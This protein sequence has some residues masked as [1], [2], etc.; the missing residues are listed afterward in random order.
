VIAPERLK[1]GVDVVTVVVAASVAL[2]LADLTWRLL[3]E[4]GG[5]AR[6]EAPAPARAARA[7]IDVSAIVALAPFGEAAQLGAVG[8]PTGSPLVLKGV[9]AAGGSS[10]SAALIEADGRVQ[11][12]AVGE[13]VPGGGV[14]EAVAVD[15]VLIRVAGRLETLAFPTGAA[16]SGSAAA[17]SPP[18]TGPATAPAARSSGVAAIRSL[19]PPEASGVARPAPPAPPAA[20]PGAALETLNRRAADNP[21]ALLQSL[22]AERTGN[23]YRIGPGVSDDLRRAGLLPGDVIERVNGAPVGDVERDRRVFEQAVASGRAR[24][25]VVRDGKRLSLSFPLR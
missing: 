18:P 4:P 14:I 12:Y 17:A 1:V 25:D 11:S 23:G 15:H 3:G 13:V 6:T 20:A 2:A 7:A 5:P 22:G 10:R 24:V 16:P 21:Q 9:F 19:I 8:A